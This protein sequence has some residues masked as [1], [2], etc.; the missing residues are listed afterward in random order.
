MFPSGLKARL[1]FSS[2]VFSVLIAFPYFESQIRIV[3]SPDV[4]TKT[5]SLVGCQANASTRSVCPLKSVAFE[6]V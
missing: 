3:L 4:D 6:K 2:L 1:R 5:E